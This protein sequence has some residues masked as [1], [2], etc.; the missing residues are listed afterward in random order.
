MSLQSETV[1]VYSLV[2]TPSDYKFTSLLQL[3]TLA[4]V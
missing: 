4:T 2:H 1:N 3:S